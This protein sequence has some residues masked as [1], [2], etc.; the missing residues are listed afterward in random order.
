MGRGRRKGL[1]KRLSSLCLAK[2]AKENK[3]IRKAHNLTFVSDHV[4]EHPLPVEW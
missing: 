1:L 2:K 3:R 4:P